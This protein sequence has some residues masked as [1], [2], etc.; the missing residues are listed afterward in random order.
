ML[1]QDSQESESNSPEVY[2]TELEEFKMSIPPDW[3][4][5]F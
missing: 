4:N 2:D 1:E 5:G 3:D